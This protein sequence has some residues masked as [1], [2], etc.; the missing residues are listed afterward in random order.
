MRVFL[1]SISLVVCFSIP[2]TATEGSNAGE[3]FFHL[4]TLGTIDRSCND[5][6]PGG[7][8]LDKIADYDS[9]M[10]REIINFCIRDALKGEMWPLESPEL[11]S[12]ETYLRNLQKNAD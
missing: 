10:L 6:H 1:V 4:N 5:C 12:L 7:K 11:K 8:G 3:A 9:T 2:V